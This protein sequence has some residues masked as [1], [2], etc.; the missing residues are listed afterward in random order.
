MKTLLPVILS[1][2]AGTRLWPASRET[3]PK[4]LLSLLGEHT[5][6]QQT[7][8][9]LQ[10][11][12]REMPGVTIRSPLVI[13][14]DTHRFIVAEQLRQIDVTP[15]RIILEPVGRNTAPAMTLAAQ[16]GNHEV[17]D[18]LLLIMPADHVIK[19][20]NAFHRAIAAASEMAD[21]SYIVT[22]GVVPHRA[23][24]GYGYIKKARTVNAASGAADIASF[25]EKPDALT[26]QDYVSS[27]DY[28]WNSGMFLCRASVWLQ[29]I[30]SF[31]NDIALACEKSI[32]QGQADMDFFRLGHNVFE[33]CPSNSIDYA[34]MEPLTRAKPGALKAG[35]VP[36]NAGW[37]DVGSWDSLWEAH[38][39]DAD[40]N[41]VRGDVY[42]DKC[43]NSLILA[44]NRYV[45]VI[46]LAD[47]VVVETADAVLV[48]SRAHAQDVKNIVAA[49]KKGKRTEALTHRKVFRP[50][51]AYEGVDIGNR[52]QVKRIT[53]NP[54][55]SLSLQ[56][57]HHRAEHWVVVHGTAQVTRGDEEFLLTENQS[58]YI[59]LGVVHR[60]AN[61]GT[62]PLEIVEVQSGAY[63]GEDDIVRFEDNYGRR[64]A[65][66]SIKK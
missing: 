14:N 26:A 49:L 38:T 64:S 24:T 17:D 58:T 1:G 55:A 27:G 3:H 12:A 8:L 52:F 53:V 22:F 41:A 65:G 57:H 33:A 6:L 46:G 9:R 42:T 45:A 13:C 7:A 40:G 34:V 43:K 21:S 15:E 44:E 20:A 23:E 16:F 39:K 50:W 62:I 36:L 11:L 35:V 59:P 63:L 19:D 29:A 48:T 4:Q 5:L 47:T 18:P 37:S 66:E 51:G 10:G 2:G 54:G 60:L 56:M 61:P 28:L 25:V 31:Q 32:A 30:S